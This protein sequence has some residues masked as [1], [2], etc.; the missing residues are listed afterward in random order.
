MQ[1]GQFRE[2]VELC[3]QNSDVKHKVRHLL[4]LSPEKWDE[5]CQHALSAVVPD[6]RPRVWWCPAIQGGLLFACKNG[7][8]LAEQPTAYVRREREG[9][10]ESVLTMQQAEGMLFTVL[11]KLKTQAM[12]DWFAPGHTGWG[13]YWHDPA[14]PLAQQL[15]PGPNGPV[16]FMQGLPSGVTTVAAL[17]ATRAGSGGMAAMQG[18][19]AAVGHAARGTAPPVA[20]A[21]SAAMQMG[22]GTSSGVHAQMLLPQQ[23]QQM[24]M[25]QQ[26]QQQQG[27]Q[28]PGMPPQQQ[29]QQ[30]VP[31]SMAMMTP[32]QQQQY[33][34]AAAAAQQQQGLLQQ[35]MVQPGSAPS[36]ATA[37]GSAGGMGF[38]AAPP[39][40][41]SVSVG[42][43]AASQRHSMPG[44]NTAKSPFAT[45]QNLQ[46]TLSAAFPAWQQG[47]SPAVSPSSAQAG[48][49]GAAAMMPQQQQQA[50]Q[51][52]QQQQ[53]QQQQLMP[54]Q[55]VPPQLVPNAN[56]NA[57]LVQ[58]QQQQQQQAQMQQQLQQQQQQAQA[59]AQLQ[60]QQQA[61]MQQQQQAQMQQQA[62]AAQQ[63]AQRQGQQQQQQAAQ[64]AALQQFQA[65][66]AAAAASA[67]AASAAAASQPQEETKLTAMIPSLEML[68]T[69][70]L[71]PIDRNSSLF[72]LPQYDSFQ[73]NMQYLAELPSG[74]GTGLDM[75]GAGAAGGAAGAGQ[76]VASAGGQA[77]GVNAVSGPMGPHHERGLSLK[78]SMSLDLAEVTEDMKPAA[79]GQ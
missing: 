38:T 26:Y 72:G 64:Q 16:S 43:A 65:A 1:V 36:T 7:A 62:A 32:E 50:Q 8:V 68:N 77:G 51:Q 52:A 58:Q 76:L 49:A 78:F 37:G 29:Q 40:P 31:Q 71:P 13:V 19:M 10:P 28:V 54:P 4:K 9:G 79:A 44:Y 6:F 22:N 53:Q 74:L 34:A 27:L 25:A 33:A 18:Q 15:Q 59:Q 21:A 67:A 55:M 46:H 20:L 70:D 24:G 30:F 2:L 41:P 17:A 69:E 11:P 75:P 56:G 14:D 48:P 73:Q 61:Q 45:N 35:R 60:Q 57:M 3:D 5:V 66:Q 42:M 39:V 12:Q 47:A 23:Q 63:Q